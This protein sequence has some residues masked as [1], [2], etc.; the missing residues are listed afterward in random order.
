MNKGTLISVSYLFGKGR[1]LTSKS[2]SIWRSKNTVTSID[3][4]VADQIDCHLVLAFTKDIPSVRDLVAISWIQLFWELRTFCLYWCNFRGKN[5][6]KPGGD[7]AAPLEDPKPNQCTFLSFG[8]DPFYWLSFTEIGEMACS[9]LAWCS[10][11]HTLKVTG[12]MV[13]GSVRLWAVTLFVEN[14][15]GGTQNK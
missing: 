4:Q 5:L 8:V 7:L 11:G 3:W 12:S 2:P 6:V 14:P 15:S 9:S 10:R 1:Y 13:L